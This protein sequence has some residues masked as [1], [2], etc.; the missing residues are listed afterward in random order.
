MPYKPSDQSGP[1]LHV[2]W[3]ILAWNVKEY[4]LQ[5]RMLVLSSCTGS[6]EPLKRTKQYTTANQWLLNKERTMVI[7]LWTG[8]P[9]PTPGKNRFYSY[10]NSLVT[11]WQWLVFKW[12]EKQRHDHVYI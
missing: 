6:Q 10:I 12:F 11:D 2:F 9:G 8:T 5:N 7:P 3:D 1:C 4:F